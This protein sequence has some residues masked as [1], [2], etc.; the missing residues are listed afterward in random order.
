MRPTPVL[1]ALI[2]LGCLLSGK[3]QAASLQISPITIILA[4]GETATTVEVTNLGGAPAAIQ[5]R[6]YLWIQSG[7]EDTLTPTEDIILSPPIFTVP[8]GASQTMRLLVRGGGVAEAERSYRL[9][10]DEVP[11]ANSR[12]KQIGFALR[13]S[14][15]V[16]LASASPTPPVLRWGVERGLDGET[17]LTAVNPGHAYDKVGAIDVTLPD[18]SHPKVI[19]RATN[20][21][22]LPGASRHWIVQGSG[23][24]PG[25]PLHLSITSRAG[26][27]E[28]SLAAP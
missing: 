21:Y 28:Q 13:V 14:L 15:P 17:Q 22:I 18:G 27:S 1:V 9:L 24:S 6:P 25:G 4:S 5:A 11:P 2:S 19:P 7:D 26:K 23:G 10:L 3:I 8:A 12:I 16:I 20:P